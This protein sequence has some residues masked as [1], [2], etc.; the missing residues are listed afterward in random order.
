MPRAL[1][2]AFAL[3]CFA[4]LAP[5][6]FTPTAGLDAW[7]RVGGGAYQEGAI[8]A[9]SGPEV[10]VAQLSNNL[11]RPGQRAKPLRGTLDTNATSVLIGLEGDVGY[12]ILPAGLPS[13]TEPDFPTFETVLDFSEEVPEGTQ[14]LILAAVDEEGNVGPEA[15]IEFD[16]AS[17]E[18]PEAVL[19]I[20][21]AWESDAD[22]DLHVVD[23]SGIEIWKGNINSYAPPLPGQPPTSTPEEGGVLDF[24][25]GADCVADGRRR[26]TVA[27]KATP[28]SGR[29]R[30]YVDTTSLCGESSA[31]WSVDAAGGEEILAKASGLATVEAEALPHGSGAGVLALEFDYP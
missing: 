19:S 14:S 20:T 25:A 26:E 31:H 21:L 9:G 10:I 6:C 22:L 12:W 23:P 17:L 18:A 2:R 4:L 24:D 16:V 1:A 5:Q 11:V 27:W 3:A 13:V 7:M 8:D 15:R 29:Y 28:P 30:V